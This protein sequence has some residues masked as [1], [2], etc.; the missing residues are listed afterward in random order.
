[1]INDIEKLLAVTK[2]IE[3]EEIYKSESLINELSLIATVRLN[4]DDNI[5]GEF[6]SDFIY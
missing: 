6:I 2:K 3:K 5:I 4:K 1:M